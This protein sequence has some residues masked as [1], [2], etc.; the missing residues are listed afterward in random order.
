[1]RYKTTLFQYVVKKK[2]ENANYDNSI[3]HTIEVPSIRVV[4]AN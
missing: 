4:L 3:I 2:M 1:M